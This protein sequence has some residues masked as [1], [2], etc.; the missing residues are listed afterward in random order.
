MD[1]PAARRLNLTMF[2][3]SAYGLGIASFLE[4]RELPSGGLRQDVLVHPA[5]PDGVRGDEHDGRQSNGSSLETRVRWTGVGTFLVRNGNEIV[6]DVAPSVQQPL[7]RTF[8]LGPVLAILLRQRGLLVLHASA[9]AVGRQACIFLGGQGWGKSTTAAALCQHGARLLSDDVTAIDTG[10][11][12]PMVIPGYPQVKLW[13]DSARAL[14]LDPAALP[15]LNDLT[16]KRIFRMLSSF[17]HEPLPL[18]RA[19]VLAEGFSLQ[20]TDLD[21][22]EALVE[23]IRHSSRVRELHPHSAPTHL[24]QCAALVNAVPV[25]RL[26]VP[27]SFKALSDVIST[28]TEGALHTAA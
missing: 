14:G 19:Y 26:T 27:R 2:M 4:L 23:L 5:T 1:Q 6:V 8:L 10:T 20:V 28:L 7:T 15:R 18:A 11:S 22:Q 16:E 21:P 12:Y 24:Q 3:Y 25:S 17:C 13:P 9:I